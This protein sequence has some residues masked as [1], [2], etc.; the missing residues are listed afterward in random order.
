MTHDLHH[1]RVTDQLI[2]LL[3]DIAKTIGI[4]EGI[5]LQTPSPRL[6]RDNRIRTLQ[7]SL[8][9]E[10]NSLSREQ[11]TALLG[12]KRVVGPKQDILEV[13]NAIR[14]YH[15]LGE[16]DPRSLSSF[17]GAH[18]ILMEGLIPSA[19]TLRKEPIGVIRPGD[20]FHE[21]PPWRQVAPMME[22]L[23]NYL[24]TTQDHLLLLSCR[25]HFQLEHIHPF[26]DGNGRMGRLWQTVLLMQYHPIFEYLPVEEFIEARQDEYYREL[27]GG[28]DTGDCTGFVDLML[29]LIRDSLDALITQTQSVIL[30]TLDR[31]EIARRSMAS[32]TFS[33]K[34]YVALFKTI[35]T[36]TASRD[37]QKGVSKGLIEKKGDKRTTLYRFVGETV[38]TGLGMNTPNDGLNNR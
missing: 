12:N 7:S 17:L 23:F 15:K 38:D 16:F 22:A 25:F 5:K 18:A 14:V 19:G 35:S 10:G 2:A 34:D 33:R 32:S 29:T 30:T 13:R 20:I 24:K 36:S 4:L 8:S 31:L 26:I 11:V 1:L 6:R 9:I 28:D 37:L 27:A 21:A 3:T